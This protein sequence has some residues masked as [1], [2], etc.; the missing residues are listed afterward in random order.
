MSR[1]THIQLA[2]FQS[3][4]WQFSGRRDDIS[5]SG[6]APIGYS[7]GEKKKTILSSTSQHMLKSI[8]DKLYI[9]I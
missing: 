5:I 8:P 3:R 9:K 1:P 2:D 4:F 6:A 7:Y